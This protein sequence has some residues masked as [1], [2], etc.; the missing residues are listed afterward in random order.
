MGVLGLG[1]CLG[2]LIVVFCPFGGVCNQNNLALL[3]RLI[4]CIEI[5]V[6]IDILTF[7]FC[8]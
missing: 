4:L 1:W 8:A 6:A 2:I 3:S 7:F 5:Y